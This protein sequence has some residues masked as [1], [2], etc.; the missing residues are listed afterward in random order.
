MPSRFETAGYDQLNTSFWS[1]TSDYSVAHLQG[2]WAKVIEWLGSLDFLTYKSSTST[3]LDSSSLTALGQST[4]EALYRDYIVDFTSEKELVARFR[5]CYRSSRSTSY[6]NTVVIECQL[7]FNGVGTG[8]SQMLYSDSNNN[9]YTNNRQIG[10][11]YSIYLSSDK[12][13]FSFAQGFFLSSSNS[14]QGFFPIAS[15]GLFVEYD[16]LTDSLYGSMCVA[17]GGVSKYYLYPYNTSLDAGQYTTFTDFKISNNVLS[18]KIIAC[19]PSGSRRSAKQ[20]SNH[21]QYTYKKFIAVIEPGNIPTGVKLNVDGISQN[22]APISIGFSAGTAQQRGRNISNYAL[23]DSYW[24]YPI[25]SV[26][27]YALIE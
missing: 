23:V 8:W 3:Y 7:L 19:L 18:E 14:Q 24:Y 13:S 1:V 2:C 10:S 4:E 17:S 12:K 5:A 25:G 15:H 22:F 9:Y 20:I 16:S 27:V 21:Y 26:C 6:K 11:P